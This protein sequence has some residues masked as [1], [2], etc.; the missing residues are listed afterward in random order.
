MIND[1]IQVG[2]SM[3]HSQSVKQFC[4]DNTVLLDVS[5]IADGLQFCSAW[6]VFQ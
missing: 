5:N 1:V 3:Y 2:E 4:I 6:I